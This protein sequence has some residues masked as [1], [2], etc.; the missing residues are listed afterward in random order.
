MV[1]YF[2]K[3]VSISALGLCLEQAMNGTPLLAQGGLG[4]PLGTGGA[5]TGETV[6][7]P[8]PAN[9]SGTAEVSAVQNLCSPELLETQLSNF[10]EHE[11]SHDNSL[12]HSNCKQLVSDTKEK[13]GKL[14]DSLQIAGQF[15]N[16]LSSER[17]SL[18]GQVNILDT[19][20]DTSNCPEEGETTSEE[21]VSEEQLSADT[22][23]CDLE[24]SDL[25]E[26]NPHGL[27]DRYFDYLNLVNPLANFQSPRFQYNNIKKIEQ[28]DDSGRIKITYGSFECID[29]PE[30]VIQKI[31]KCS[32]TALGLHVIN[33]KFD[34]VDQR[35]EGSGYRGG[36]YPQDESGCVGFGEITKDYI[37]CKELLSQANMLATSR[38]AL[39]IGHQA[40]TQMTQ[41]KL[42]AEA[43]EKSQLGD[44]TTA[45]M[46]ALQKG[47]NTQF[48]HQTQ[49][50]GFSALEMAT[51]QS[52]TSKFPTP[53]KARDLWVSEGGDMNLIVESTIKA[54]KEK[55]DTN[56]AKNLLGSVNVEIIVRGIEGETGY[57]NSIDHALREFGG[58]LFANG[59][60]LNEVKQRVNQLKIQMITEG[61]TA[62]LLKRQANQ[63]SKD[64]DALQEKKDE[65]L[66]DTSFDPN[67]SV[68]PCLLNPL[69]PACQNQ[70]ETNTSPNNV[71]LG[72]Y[73]FGNEGGQSAITSVSE[74]GD[75]L[76]LSPT[77]DLGVGDG[78]VPPGVQAQIAKKLSDEVPM[79]SGGGRPSL[80]GG[81]GGAPGGGGGGGGGLPAGGGGSG[82]GVSSKDFQNR[83][84]AQTKGADAPDYRVTPKGNWSVGQRS[85]G[86]KNNIAD[87]FKKNAKANI[88][89]SILNYRLPASI[90]ESSSNI[91]QRISSRY[92]KMEEAKRLLEYETQ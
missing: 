32:S 34:K 1:R 17:D 19:N 90:S 92:D 44:S 73:N 81:Q 89:N 27:H 48:H 30:K 35:H 10:R 54:L 45:S 28:A 70:D 3:F 11:N 18:L 60:R 15:C 46:E 24:C 38:T 14:R 8:D 74:K 87:L 56:N 43:W 50:A 42:Q 25:T 49:K 40:H 20:I 13:L 31:S 78:A 52:K 67:L 88:K 9:P 7:T 82:G 41:G 59:A 75:P 91:F 33:R 69:I 21:G 6:N 37:P 55:T 26:I 66:N 4:L 84:P 5:G 76:G 39:D 23:A 68:N 51:L 16:S 22:E 85:S 86:R 58:G 57:Q 80:G 36:R 2:I 79:P 62:A 64:I 71:M 65:A 61:A 47:T 12:S 83:S 63:L 77:H 72:G 53:Q 29:S